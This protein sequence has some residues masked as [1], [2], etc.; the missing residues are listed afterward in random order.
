[1]TAINWVTLLFGMFLLMCL[2]FWLTHEI[3]ASRNHKR[4]ME[5][6][7]RGIKAEVPEEHR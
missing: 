2:Y 6:H 4:R 7:S 1:M 3:S 5:L